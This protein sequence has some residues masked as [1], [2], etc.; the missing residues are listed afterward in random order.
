MVVTVAAARHNTRPCEPLDH[1]HRIEVRGLQDGCEPR[2]R[3]QQTVFH[4]NGG[5]SSVTSKQVGSLRGWAVRLLPP[6]PSPLLNSPHTPKL[7]EPPSLNR[8]WL[9][10]SLNP[11]ALTCKS[12]S[13]IFDSS[14]WYDLPSRTTP[15]IAPGLNGD[16][17]LHASKI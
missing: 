16:F 2:G 1:T 14:A 11:H 17:N 13:L 12:G 9:I 8:P 5:G 3:L 4:L 6:P 10:L 7:P 15:A